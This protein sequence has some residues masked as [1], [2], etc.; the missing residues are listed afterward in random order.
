[1]LSIIAPAYNEE[2]NLSAFLAAIVPVLDA[3]GEPFE[4]IFVD[5]GSRDGTLGML[6]AARSQDARIKIVSFARNFGKDIALS[7]G[8]AHASGR[9]VIPIDCDLQ[10]PAVS[11]WAGRNRSAATRSAAPRS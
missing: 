3:I 10:H 6:A 5:D 4:I 2:H 1:M 11:S 9:A 8:I 7:A